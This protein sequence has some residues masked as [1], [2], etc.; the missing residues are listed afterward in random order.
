VFERSEFFSS[1]VEGA[2]VFSYTFLI[3]LDF[4]FF[5]SRKRKEE[6][7]VDTLDL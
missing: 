2:V 6:K 5:L 1:V 4:C 3:S 7:R